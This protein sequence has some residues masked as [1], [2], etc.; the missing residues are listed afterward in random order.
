MI[1]QLPPGPRRPA[2]PE[3]ESAPRR[4]DVL[5]RAV[6]SGG[7][8]PPLDEVVDA[9]LPW[10]VTVGADGGVRPGRIVIPLVHGAACRGA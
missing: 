4:T 10:F 6:R 5:G 3:V 8:H 1:R 9:V 2:A 7:Y